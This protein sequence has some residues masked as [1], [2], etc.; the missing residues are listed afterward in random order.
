MTDFWIWKYWKFIFMSPPPIW[1]ILAC[2]IPQFLA[3]SYQFRQSNTDFLGSSSWTNVDN[4]CVNL[5]V[6]GEHL[7]VE[8]LLRWCAGEVEHR[9]FTI[10]NKSIEFIHTNAF[11]YTVSKY[12]C[13][14]NSVRNLSFRLPSSQSNFKNISL[15]PHNFA[16]NF[17]LMWLVYAS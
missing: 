12:R 6:P 9:C 1:Y 10:F 2:N 11:S 4:N 8:H 15:A 5:Y 17:Y 3:E 13:V 7:I 16:G 14:T